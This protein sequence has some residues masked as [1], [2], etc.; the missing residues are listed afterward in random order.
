VESI[1]GAAGSGSLKP[2]V[3][4]S[5]AAME[6]GVLAIEG[7]ITMISF[8]QSMLYSACDYAEDLSQ[9]QFLMLSALV[10]LVGGFCLRGFG[11]RI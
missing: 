7:I 5:P 6:A 8:F 2:A 4:P 3:L 10:V 1:H 11:E 9:M